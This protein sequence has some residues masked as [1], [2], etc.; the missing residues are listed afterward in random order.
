MA[1][2]IL[3]A[4]LQRYTDGTREFEVAA[5]TYQSL[6]TE[7]RQLFPALPEAIIA[8]HAIAIDGVLIQTPLLETFDQDSELLFIAKI[9]GG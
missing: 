9:A 5:N 6:V 4:E 1:K 2:V 7:L 3:S 8:K